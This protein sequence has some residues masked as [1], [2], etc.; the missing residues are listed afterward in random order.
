MLIGLVARKQSGKST[1][2]DYLVK[3]YSFINQAFADPIKDACKIIFDFSDE[4]TEGVLKEVMDKRWG[5]TPRQ[6][7]QIIGTDVF[8]QHLP[9]TVPGLKEIG[10]QF[11]IE[12]FKIWYRKNMDKNV[13]VSDV[14][15]P[16][17]AQLIRDMGGVIVKIQRSGVKNGDTH[18]SETLIDNIEEDSMIR[19]DFSLETY[20]QH[21]DELMSHILSK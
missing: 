4:Q 14:R 11:W 3:E 8:R 5:I 13:I 6:A 17:E 21:I 2:A 10:D 18:I 1:F 12:R 20:Y 16:N 15:F 19:N 9:K 7:F